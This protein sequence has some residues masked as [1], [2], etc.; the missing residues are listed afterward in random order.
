MSIIVWRTFGIEKAECAGINS[1]HC[2]RK[3]GYLC[4]VVHI[5]YLKRAGRIN[6]TQYEICVT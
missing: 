3:K 6:V 1:R 5:G 2:E 4:K